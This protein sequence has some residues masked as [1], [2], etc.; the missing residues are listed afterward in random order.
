MRFPGN[1]TPIESIVDVENV[2]G[3]GG[4]DQLSGDGGGNVLTGGAGNDLLDGRGGDDR[5]DG[6]EG[7]DELIGGDGDD[8]LSGGTGADSFDGGD[9]S[10]TV[11]YA[12]ET[13]G[14]VPH[15]ALE[16][17]GMRFGPAGAPG[18]AFTRERENVGSGK[19]R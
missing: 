4:H 9:G 15:A 14:V 6:G 16:A 5:L 17:G 11:S 10:D 3:G 18:G 7:I 8:W 2:I 13:P 12:F 19:R 1:P